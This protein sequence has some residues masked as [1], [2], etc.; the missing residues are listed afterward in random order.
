MFR[1]DKLEGARFASLKTLE[2]WHNDF[3]GK[4]N[5][6]CLVYFERLFYYYPKLRNE[7]IEYQ[8]RLKEDKIARRVIE[9]VRA[10]HGIISSSREKNLRRKDQRL[11]ECDENQL[12]IDVMLNPKF[13]F[14]W[15]DQMLELANRHFRALLKDT[16]LYQLGF[17]G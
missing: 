4:K 15:T 6:A 16:M 8:K 2:G 17:E 3:F 7:M 14:V 10:M 11:E 9:I 5:K 1:R 12:V 13:K